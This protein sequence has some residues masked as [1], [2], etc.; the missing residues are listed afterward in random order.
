M[1]VLRHHADGVV[2]AC[3][4]E[5]ADVVT[6]DAHRAGGDVVEP[7]HERRE[8]GLARA[9]RADERDQLTRCDRQVDVAQYFGGFAGEVVHGVESRA[10]A[11][12]SRR[13]AGSGT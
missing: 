1:R 11:L 6:V 3:L 12:M 13:R 9:R 5:I 2:H 4:C 10:T 7:R 8:G